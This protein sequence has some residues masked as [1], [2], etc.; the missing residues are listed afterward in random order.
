MPRYTFRGADVVDLLE[1]ICKSMGFPLHSFRRI[2]SC[3]IFLSSDRSITSFFSLVSRLRAAANDVFWAAVVPP[4]LFS[5]E[6]S[7]LAD[8]GLA[9]MFATGTPS[10][11]LLQDERLLGV[12]ELRS[13]HR[14]CS[15][16]PGKLAAKTLT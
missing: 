16:Q 11:P 13:L 3:S 14:R 10:L 9:Q 6:V 2:M 15:F 8:P 1:R 7:H 5:I 12:R 4:I